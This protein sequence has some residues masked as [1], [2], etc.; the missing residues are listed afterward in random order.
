M[1]TTIVPNFLNLPLP[2]FKLEEIETANQILYALHEGNLEAHY[3]KKVNQLVIRNSQEIARESLQ[4]LLYKPTYANKYR[5]IYPIIDQRDSKGNWLVAFS[6]V[7]P[8]VR[9]Y[10]LP[11]GTLNKLFG[12]S[13][14]DDL[15]A[16]KKLFTSEFLFSQAEIEE[17]QAEIGQRINDNVLE[18]MAPKNEMKGIWLWSSFQNQFGNHPL[19]TES[20]CSGG[21]LDESFF[22]KLAPYTFEIKPFAIPSQAI[23]AIFEGPSFLDCGAV[24]TA[25]CY[26]ALLEI[27]GEDKFNAFFNGHG[28][29]KLQITIAPTFQNNLLSYFTR[30]S[31]QAKHQKEG[32]INQRPLKL[33]DLC[34]FQG[35]K[36]YHYKFPKGSSGSWNAA[37]A[38]RNKNGDQIFVAQNFPKPLTE[39]EIYELFIT[40]YNLFPKKAYAITALNSRLY[41]APYIQSFLSKYRVINQAQIKALGYAYFLDGY[42]HSFT[43]Q[44]KAKY[45]LALLYTKD[46]ENLKNELSL[47]HSFFSLTIFDAITHL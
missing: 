15:K 24:L 39:N 26:K 34:S 11:S 38:G 14:Q 5:R 1:N 18:V 41:E 36:F 44:I 6:K 43:R 45:V 42:L 9:P 2:L 21:Y 30:F 13:I 23:Q 47:R 3:K 31:R 12:Y 40:K 32:K 46:V 27:V 17:M 10:I 16:T 7:K 4:D 19:F 35:V 22:E 29:N 28:K 8:A 37:Y 20:L 25:C 33:G